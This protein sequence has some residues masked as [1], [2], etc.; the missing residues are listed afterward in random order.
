MAVLKNRAGVSTATV[1]TGTL[2]LGPA[3]PA[4]TSINAASW[5]SFAAANVAD[6]DVVR[7]LILDINGNWEYGPGTYGAA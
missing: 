3:L 5:Q 7:Y 1:G 4:G 2:T 6:L